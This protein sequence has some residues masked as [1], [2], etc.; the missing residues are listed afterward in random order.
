MPLLG[1]HQA[2]RAP[3]S[4]WQRTVQALSWPRPGGMLLSAA[5]AAVVLAAA[6]GVQ[7]A[8]PF[9]STTAAPA[10][11][12]PE[13]AAVAGNGPA[14]GAPP[15][16]PT[17]AAGLAAHAGTPPSSI[18]GGAPTTAAPVPPVASGP[19]AAAVHNMSNP[20]SVLVLVNKHHPLNPLDYQPPDLVTPNVPAG[21]GE[22]VL[23]RREAA[24]AVERMFAAAGSNG[25][26]ITVQ[27][28]YR[29]YAT[30]VS[31]YGSYVAQK[32]QE[33]ADT[34]SARP[35]YSEHQTGLA[36]DIGDANVGAD[37]EFTIC[38]EETA[39]GRW[40]AAHAADY[41]FVVRYP[42]GLQAVTG[43]LYEPW[44]LRY[45]GTAAALDMR[46]RGIPTYEQYLG[47]QGAPGY[48]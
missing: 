45:V 9:Q 43:Y 25:V 26:S 29:S 47:L 13:P 6:V 40:V 37:C 4:R 48:K 7:S 30:Q 27:S 5:G 12:S 28:S 35:G 17:A 18:P 14:S 11:R 34:S 23:L 21:P 16:L 44:H 41:G 33:S 20:A 31:L 38:V 19:Q 22:L 3:L 46:A 39:A 10:Q 32:G 24:A 2:R 36:L 15:V 42:P 1:F 8:Y